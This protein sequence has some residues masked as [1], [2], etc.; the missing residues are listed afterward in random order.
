MDAITNMQMHNHPKTTKKPAGM[1]VS[2]W[3]CCVWNVK[4]VKELFYKNSLRAPYHQPSK[5]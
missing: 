2:H 1:H 3:T 5:I 4:A